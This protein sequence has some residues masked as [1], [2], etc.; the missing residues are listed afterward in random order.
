MGTIKILS[1]VGAASPNLAERVETMGVL[2]IMLASAL[3]VH[4]GLIQGIMHVG[5]FACSR[6]ALAGSV[7]TAPFDGSTHGQGFEPKKAGFAAR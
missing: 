4:A 5:I 6:H 7:P 3:G 2:S 1:K